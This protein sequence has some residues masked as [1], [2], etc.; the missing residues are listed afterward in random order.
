MTCISSFSCYNV[1]MNKEK[2]YNNN[3]SKVKECNNKNDKKGTDFQ[4][5]EEHNYCVIENQQENNYSKI[6][7]TDRTFCKM[8]CIAKYL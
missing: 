5:K 4:M 8:K 2:D 7:G 6:D 1:D 3:I